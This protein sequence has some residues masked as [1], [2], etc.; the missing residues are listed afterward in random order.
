VPTCTILTTEPN[1][2]AKPVHDRIPV[3]LDPRN[4]KRWLD[5]AVNVPAE[6][7]PLL[8]PFPAE[9]MTAFPVTTAVNNPAFDDPTCLVPASA[10]EAGP[11]PPGPR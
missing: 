3:I 5:P 8:R 6:V 9:T 2:I 10:S 4:Y 7:R 11:P 1:E